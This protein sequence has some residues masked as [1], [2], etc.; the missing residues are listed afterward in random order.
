MLDVSHMGDADTGGMLLRLLYVDDDPLLRVIAPER[1]R[2][3]CSEIRT[4]CDGVEG[5][6]AISDAMPDLILLDLEM[7]RMNGFDVLKKLRSSPLT[8]HIPVIVVTSRADDGAI[9]L[10]FT[11]GA[12]SFVLKPINWQL[13]L[14]QI[15]FV[16]RAA[17]NELAL[18]QHVAALETTRDELENTSDELRIALRKAAEAST[19]KSRFLA[20]MSHE[21]RT[22]LNAVI[23]FSSLLA[24]ESS[25]EEFGR[26]AEYARDI[27]A[28]G[29]HLLQL[30]NNIL[31][32]ARLDTGDLT[33]MKMPVD[34][35]EVMRHA[36]CEIMATTDTRDVVVDEVLAAGVALVM[37]DERRLRQ[38]FENILSN[39]VKFSPSGGR[40]VVETA[41]DGNGVLVRIADQGIGMR[42]ADIQRVIEPFSQLDD[43]LARRFEGAGLG[44]PLA[45]RLIDLHQGT[46]EIISNPGEGTD[47]R[48]HLPATSSAIS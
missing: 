18:V 46:L 6:K 36:V 34:V 15:R 11:S 39:A 47:V 10:A 17:N 29:I 21:L 8:L 26:H 9:E 48:I 4:A 32:I 23:G 3:I 1:L 28:S 33:L 20:S 43:Q 44:L 27:N 13:L 16:H 35:S 41:M 30:V 37:A 24:N 45:K 14:H 2:S 5:L 31:D 25:S 40:V 22:P 12:T 19:A 38:A 42:C 7:P